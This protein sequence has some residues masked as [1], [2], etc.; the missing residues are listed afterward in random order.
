MDRMAGSGPA[1][2]GSIPGKGGYLCE[3]G[4]VDDFARRINDLADSPQLRKK[5]GEFNRAR[6][7]NKFTL[8]KMAK[9]Y[10]SLFEE[11]LS[12]EK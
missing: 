2:P 3:L 9:N 7:E 1:D 11:V 8:T 5:I 10:H 6:I 4:N 12:S